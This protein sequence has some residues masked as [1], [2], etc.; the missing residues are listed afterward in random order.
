MKIQAKLPDGD[1]N[2]LWTA[3]QRVLSRPKETIMVVATLQCELIEE[4]PQDGTRTP[5]MKITAIEPL[6]LN[7]HVAEAMELMQ[8][9]K[10]DRTGQAEIRHFD[11]P[12]TLFDGQNGRLGS[13]VLTR[14]GAGDGAPD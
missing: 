6:T 11:E 3:D 7:R 12:D 4:R 14:T 5:V 1:K 8:S 2:G 13:T 10:E 9:A